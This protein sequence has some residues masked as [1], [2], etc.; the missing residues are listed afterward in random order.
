MVRCSLVF[1]QQLLGLGKNGDALIAIS[2]TGNSENCVLA[3]T[4]A[5]AMGVKVI[6]MTGAN[7]S[8]L[9]RLADVSIRVPETETYKVQELHLPVYHAI[10]AALEEEFF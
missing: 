7:E 8:R 3:A 2:T 1:A 6:A 4:L 10:A 5:K 9:S